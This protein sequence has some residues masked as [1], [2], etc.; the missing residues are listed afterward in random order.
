MQIGLVPGN[1]RDE[2]KH[3]GT[4]FVSVRVTGTGRP[5]PRAGSEF[6]L[7]GASRGGWAR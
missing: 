1:L 6:H 2:V 3:G 4:A 7:A 5:D